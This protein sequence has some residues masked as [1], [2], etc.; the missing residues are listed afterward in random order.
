MLG[1]KFSPAEF[2]SD[3]GGERELTESPPAHR[4]RGP[5]AF[6]SV[7]TF[8][9]V[10]ALLFFGAGIFVPLV[11]SILLAFAL[12]PLVS[13]M[14]RRLRIPDA[15]AVVLAVL[16]A[17]AILI[18]F[19]AMAGLQIANLVQE[20]PRY[21]QI[22]QAKV[23]GLQS[24]FGGLVWFDQLTSMAE[25]LGQRLENDNA[26][27]PG[28]MRPIPVSI[29]N[30]IGPLAVLTSVMG[31]VVGPIATGAIVIVF[32]VFLLLGR[33]DMQERFIRLV[34]GGRYS[35]TNLAITDASDRVGRY[36]VIQL[37]VNSTYGLIFGT[38]LW[39]IGVPSAALWGLLIVLFRYIPFV[40]A[41]MVAIVPFVLAFA[42][43]PGWNMLL[44]TL[45]LFLVIDLTTAN[46]IEPRLY[47]SST[48]VSP[49]AIL[50]SAMF[51][52]TLWGPVGLILATPMTVCLVVSKPCLA[53]SRCSHLPS[54]STSACSRV[55][56]KTPS[57]CPKPISKNTTALPGAARCYCRP[58]AW[59]ISSFPTGPNPSPSA[60][61]SPICSI[62]CSP[63]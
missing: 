25:G 11:L 35:R 39:L 30:E 49:I 62:R 45:G 58:C 57:S 17:V 19:S 4:R 22:V 43:D 48:G 1:T 8:A 50:L 5:S 31:S 51:W 14:S 20:L 60:G 37:A 10:A 61:F 3:P 26:P 6:E 23:E 29:S 21:R 52:A 27:P 44:L 32:L 47:G 15:V 33:A 41:L 16:I 56:Q 7:A 2:R 24:Q 63:P 9:I 40:G 54:A 13:W 53:A 42:I 59:Q 36:L 18:A 28:Q 34:S 55:R 38:G 12:N 46:V